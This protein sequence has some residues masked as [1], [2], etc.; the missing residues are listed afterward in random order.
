[1]SYG[2]ENVFP[3]SVS[4][5]AVKHVIELLG[6]KKVSR[7]FKF[8]GHV[9]SYFWYEDKEYR[10]WSGV[11][12]SVYKEGGSLK[13]STRSTISRSYWD[14]T[15][16][17]KTIKTLRDLF[18]GKFE[19]DE[20][21]SRYLRPESP[22]PL[23]IASGCYLARW[24]F[25]N[26]LG[27]AQIYLSSRVLKGNMAKDEPS[28]LY[29]VDEMNPKLLSNNLVVPY[30]IGIWEEFFRSCFIAA[31]MHVDDR[32]RI[33]KEARLGHATLEDI[34]AQNTSIEEAI[35][36]H[37]SFQRPSQIAKNFSLLDSSFDLGA[38]IKK[39]YRGRKVNL[40]ESIENLVNDRN[41]LVHEGGLNLTLFDKELK[42]VLDDI[43]VAVDRAY[44]SIGSK[45]K[46]DPIEVW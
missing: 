39:P 1:M 22:P 5:D 2:T 37:F 29:Y 33:L 14:L 17:N 12:L 19:T 7:P 18:G 10:S 21:R 23:P 34:F 16:Q 30:V 24:R 43:E 3:K 45:F 40:Y 26:A 27:R 41:S 13:V 6:F 46:F 28:G 44:A 35:A 31:M 42:T 36:G 4:P 32:K 20:G 9:A 38:A 11:E 15:H 25:H 8:K